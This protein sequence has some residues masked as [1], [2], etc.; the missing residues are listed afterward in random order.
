MSQ[1][2]DNDLTP[3]F[4]LFEDIPK[5]SFFKSEDRW[6][7]IWI[8]CIISTNY[9]RL[10][11]IIYR[12]NFEYP[13]LSTSPCSMNLVSAKYMFWSGSVFFLFHICRGLKIS[14][15][16]RYRIFRP[17]TCHHMK[18]DYNFLDFQTNYQSP[19]EKFSDGDFSY[20]DGLIGITIL[21]S[22]MHGKI[23]T[24]MCGILCCLT[25]MRAATN[26]SCGILKNL[27]RL[28]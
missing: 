1:F 17:L 8:K 2:W 19:S 11:N 10:W 13:Q 21:N 6:L 15:R 22:L 7:S 3:C 28:D 14:N 9:C 4:F 5:N 26:T 12:L 18:L 25:T 24:Y 20:G 23:C 16:D 27:R